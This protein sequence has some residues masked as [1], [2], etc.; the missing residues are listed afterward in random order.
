MDT[1]DAV[2]RPASPLFRPWRVTGTEM[3]PPLLIMCKLLFV[4]LLCEHILAQIRPP[5]LPFLGFLDVFRSWPGPY[6][7]AFEAVFLLAGLCLWLNIRPRAASVVLGLCVLLIMV[8]SKPLFRNHVFVVGCLFLL[9]GL[10]RPGARPFL[11]YLQLSLIYLGAFLNKILLE[12]W[13]TG[14]FMDNFLGNARGNPF[15]LALVDVLPR[16]WVARSLSWGTIAVELAIGLGFLFG[17]T[18][19]AA[20]WLAVLFHFGLYAFLL[21]ETFGHFLENLLLAFIVV[22]DW[23]QTPVCLSPRRDSF[24]MARRIVA[25]LDWDRVFVVCRPDADPSPVTSGSAISLDRAGWGYVLRRT[26]GFYIVLFIAYQIVYTFA[27]GR[28]PLVVT[29]LVAAFLMLLFLP[30]ARLAGR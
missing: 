19:A 22:L 25:L 18:R 1:A 8:S 27:P 9:A 29:S 20:V 4:L 30:P 12:D 13:A 11:L 24:G 28:V 10:T 3:L 7:F 5:F 17:R 23:P 16:M 26:S 21:G 2:T 15:Y 14:Q 6:E